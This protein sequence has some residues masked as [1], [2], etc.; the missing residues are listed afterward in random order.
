MKVF[1]ARFLS[2]FFQRL[3]STFAHLYD[4]FAAFISGGRWHQWNLSIL[5][6]IDGPIILELGHGTGL[7]QAALAENNK[8][9]SYALDISPQMNRIAR[10]RLDKIG[11]DRRIVQ[12]DA[13]KLPYKSNTFNQVISVF[14]SE[15]I[16]NA[17]TLAEAQRVLKIKGQLLIIPTA[18][19]TGKS[20]ID[21]LLAYIFYITGETS[22]FDGK[23]SS[24]LN[25]A[26]FAIEEISIEM[27][28]SQ[29]L[30]I[31]ARLPE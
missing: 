2:Y 27:D 11:A 15:Y 14:P 16:L 10:K 13:S 1:L 20:L 3:Y 5:P 31:S 24:L 17:N 25:E 26:G 12:S 22:Q 6:F 19:I 30:L 28:S 21:R 7:V 9:R 23:F 29:I 8:L 18:K 4:I